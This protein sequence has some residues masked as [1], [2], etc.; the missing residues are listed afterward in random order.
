MKKT[1]FISIVC[2]IFALFM[3]GCSAVNVAQAE[4]EPAVVTIEPSPEPTE[5]PEPEPQYEVFLKDPP[6]IFVIDERYKYIDFDSEQPPILFASKEDMET[7]AA[8]ITD[9]M[10]AFGIPDFRLYYFYDSN[11]EA[12]FRAYGEKYEILYRENNDGTETKFIAAEPTE[13]GGFYKVIPQMSDSGMEYNVPSLIPVDIED[14][15]FSQSKTE[16]GTDSENSGDGSTEK[17]TKTP[18]NNST[19]AES[20]D[21][22]GNSY[23]VNTVQ[24]P[25][26]STDSTLSAPAPTPAPTPAP[27]TTPPNGGAVVDLPDYDDSA[28]DEWVEDWIDHIEN[29]GTIS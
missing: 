18:S 16:S 17:N 6:W 21:S 28:H 15:D 3:V 20:I 13:S 11:G 23:T 14:E 9:Y 24:A 7:N 8:P 22:S 12:Q 29:G 2:T 10:I 1:I 4:T 27:P 26:G 25:T 19:G 5:T